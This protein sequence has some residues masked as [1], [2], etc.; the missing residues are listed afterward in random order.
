MVMFVEKVLGETAVAQHGPLLSKSG[1]PALPES[2]DEEYL[3]DV[4]AVSWADHMKYVDVLT[5][6]E[7][8]PCRSADWPAAPSKMMMCWTLAMEYMD[9]TNEAGLANT[10][11][12]ESSLA[13]YLSP[14]HDHGVGGPTTLP[15][16]QC[17]F[18]TLQLDSLKCRRRFQMT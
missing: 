7:P 6:E 1:A 2:E 13:A 17:R 5:E 8:E 18:S 9:D 11:R 14:S 16:K 10:P 12:M 4:P 3:V 15:Y